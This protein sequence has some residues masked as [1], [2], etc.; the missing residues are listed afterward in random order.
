MKRTRSRKAKDGLGLDVVLGFLVLALCV[1]VF[2]L[3]RTNS[4]L[5]ARLTAVQNEDRDR[6]AQIF[7]KMAEDQEEQG[8]LRKARVL[9][10]KE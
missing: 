2:A 5:E 3:H 9:L 8:R 6:A 1:Y 10:K 7:V 4:R